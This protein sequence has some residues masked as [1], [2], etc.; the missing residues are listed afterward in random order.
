MNVCIC[1]ILRQFGTFYDQP[2]ADSKHF[3]PNALILCFEGVEKIL[4]LRLFRCSVLL[5]Y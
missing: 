1:L 2:S 3:R 5:F 4:K